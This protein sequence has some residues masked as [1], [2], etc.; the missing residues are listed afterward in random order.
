MD[1]I[2]FDLRVSSINP[3]VRLT[4]A[5]VMA[6]NEIL[7]ALPAGGA[8]GDLCWH[9]TS[10][11]TCQLFLSGEPDGQ[12]IVSDGTVIR[13]SPDPHLERV[14]EIR[15]DRDHTLAKLLVG[16]FAAADRRDTKPPQR[17][18]AFIR[19]AGTQPPAYGPCT[20]G[21]PA[22]FDRWAY[23]EVLV[24]SNCYNFA[25]KDPFCDKGPGMPP[26]APT[27]GSIEKWNNALS[28]A[29]LIPTRDWKRAPAGQDP[30]HGWHI[31]LAL[32]AQHHFHFLRLD[33]PQKQWT[34]KFSTRLPQACDGK[35]AA[36]PT[37]GIRR[38][39][40]CG[41]HVKAFYWVPEG[42]VIGDGQ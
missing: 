4:A 8:G 15:L 33:R 40:L 11:R 3:S 7:R 13:S 42:V 16:W 5:D 19:C 1:P 2:A 37:G 31:A 12:L 29:G 17:A 24:N 30:E 38:A 21:V 22:D 36:I 32:D 27:D 35:G 25:M 10:T 6:V 9:C 20:C 23:L 41:Y 34:H 39:H 28:N 14:A 18:A 26:G